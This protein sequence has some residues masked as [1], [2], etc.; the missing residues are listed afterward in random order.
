MEN[1]EVTLRIRPPNSKE[2]EC[3]DLDVWSVIENNQ[4]GIN[5]ERYHD[6]IRYRKIYPG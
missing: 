5:Q 1:I 4:I 2:I 6:L 3:S